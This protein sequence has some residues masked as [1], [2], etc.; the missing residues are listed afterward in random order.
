MMADELQSARYADGAS[1]LYFCITEQGHA[2]PGRIVFD[3][4]GRLAKDLFAAIASGAIQLYAWATSP[5]A[6]AA[7][8]NCAIEGARH[9]A[10][11]FS[12]FDE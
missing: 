3:D 9:V 10:P 11:S 6:E 5:L 1:P 4:A 7:K 8:A 12:N 2:M